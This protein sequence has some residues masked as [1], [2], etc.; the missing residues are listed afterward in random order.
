MTRYVTGHKPVASTIIKTRAMNHD[1]E[2]A[3]VYLEFSDDPGFKGLVVPTA[4]AITVEASE[5]GEI[6][7]SIP[8]GT[9]IDV[10][11]ADYIRPIALGSI[12]RMKATIT[13]PIVGAAYWRMVVARY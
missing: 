8:D 12:Q 7:G 13:T 6:Y 3:Y 11:T 9:A 1:F 5:N 2:K 4:G 10:T